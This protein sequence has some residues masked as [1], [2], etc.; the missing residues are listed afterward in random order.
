VLEENYQL[1]PLVFIG[2]IDPSAGQ[3]FSSM[4]PMVLSAI[5]GALGLGVVFLVRMKN[6]ILGIFKK[7]EDEKTEE[8]SDT[9]N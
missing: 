2:Y 6:R 5:G 9:G 8:S 3:V 4:G 1:F 7:G